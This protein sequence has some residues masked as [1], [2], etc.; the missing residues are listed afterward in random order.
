MVPRSVDARVVAS[1]GEMLEEFIRPLGH[2]A[3][4]LAA[5]AG[6]R[7]TGNGWAVMR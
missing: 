2:R 4:T 1:P 5:T 6:V 7:D 3:V